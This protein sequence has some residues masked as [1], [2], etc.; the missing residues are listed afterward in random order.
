[1]IFVTNPNYCKEKYKII[2]FTTTKD[3]NQKNLTN[4]FLIESSVESDLIVYADSENSSN[5]SPL[6]NL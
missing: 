3:E 1:M 6:I 4:L 5:S 2:K